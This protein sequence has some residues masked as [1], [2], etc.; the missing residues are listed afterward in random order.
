VGSVLSLSLIANGG[1]VTGHGRF[2]KIAG[3]PAMGYSELY[4]SDL[5]LSPPNNSMMGPVRRL[6]APPAP[7]PVTYDGFYRI[8][9]MPAGTYSIYVNQPDFFISP[10]VVPNVNIPASGTVTVNV[11]LDVD[12]S[13]AFTGDQQWTEWA[14]DNYQ[15]FVA[16]GA[17]VRGITWRMAGSGLYDGKVGIVKVLED[18]G[19]ANP[20]NWKLV[21]WGNDPQVNADSDEWVRFNSGQIPLTAG[22]KYA[23]GVHIE[24]GEAIYKRNKDA[25]SYS[26]GTAYD[27]NGV[28]RPYDLNITVFTDP[29]DGGGDDTLVTHTRK[30]PGPGVFDGSL[31]STTWG[32][33]FVATGTS[34][35]AADLF[36]AG[37][38][39]FALTW[40]VRDGGPGGPQIGP[41]KNVQG[42]Y[43]AST[44]VLAG[45]SWNPG[46]ITLVPGHT[47][48]IE[49][50]NAGGFTPYLQE[51]W[52]A[53][54]DGDAYRNG[55][56][57]AGSDLAMTILEYG[58]AGLHPTRVGY[59]E[60][61]EPAMG[62]GSYSPGAGASEM[63]FTTTSTNLGAS[64]LAGTVATVEAPTTP[65]LMHRGV[66]ATT[67][68]DA[69][70][71]SALHQAL[72]SMMVRVGKTGYED[73]DFLRVYI[74]DGT[75]NIDLLNELGS[76]ASTSDPLE[77]LGDRAY[78][79]VE[80]LVPDSWSSVR[81]VMSSS[82][83]STAGAEFYSIDSI[84]F[85]GVAVP[86]PT[87]LLALCGVS[88][89][90]RRR[91]GLRRGRAL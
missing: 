10:K 51:K 69:I 13:T 86:E 56:L 12:Y 41:T 1:T 24:G 65:V 37:P 61:S 47:Y 71:L 49:A 5:F 11:D 45:V 60:F 16:K 22:K 57:R 64:P 44:T 70:Q 6:G 4:E 54:A 36:A 91:I 67:T 68:F 62:A 25:N 72:V 80:G 38:T 40:R 87:T 7:D 9:G 76:T 66:S 17:S 50:S 81:L 30:S 21:G 59:T 3:N 28:A 29:A 82:S 75:S 78:F 23:I 74:T 18:N 53:F 8:D 26:Q 35:A 20:A 19:S 2:L 83:N 31:N 63:G 34:L 48:Y 32:Q 43:F 73:G 84:N 85:T 14:W 15:T 89:L 77:V 33:S 90:L 42:A 46:E 79:R 55:T 52:N 39:G 58:P 27:A 88:F